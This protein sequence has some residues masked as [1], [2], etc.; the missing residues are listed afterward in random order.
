MP[1]HS[2]YCGDNLNEYFF[3][4]FTERYESLCDDEKDEKERMK[5]IA[6]SWD[7]VELEEFVTDTI[8]SFETV[9]KNFMSAI[10]GSIDYDQLQ[11]DLHGWLE[12]IEL[13]E[14]DEEAVAT[15]KFCSDAS[16]FLKYC[17]ECKELFCSGCGSHNHHFE[18]LDKPIEI[19]AYNDETN[20]WGK[21]TVIRKMYGAL[22][23]GC[24]ND[25]IKAQ[26]LPLP[27][28]HL[29]EWLGASH[30]LDS[31]LCSDHS[32]PQENGQATLVESPV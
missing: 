31:T 25:V 16:R 5:K 7:Q 20:S 24:K 15:C 32:H 10:L 23:D 13:D 2:T 4:V 22:C 19:K 18:Q 1:H 27:K 21:K 28:E 14:E 30:P 3:A 9:S 17:Y 26:G 12:E 6:A 29:K 11:K 8:E